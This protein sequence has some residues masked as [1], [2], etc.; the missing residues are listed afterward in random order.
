MGR[1]ARVA[2]AEVYRSI[3][4]SVPPGY[5]VLNAKG[6]E[7]VAAML[8]PPHGVSLVAVEAEFRQ[9]QAQGRKVAYFPQPQRPAAA[10]RLHPQRTRCGAGVGR[11]AINCFFPAGLA[12]AYGPRRAFL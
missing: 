8:F 4:A 5:I 7:E 2:N 3:D 11:F 6:G 9:L 1:A 12:T 10:A